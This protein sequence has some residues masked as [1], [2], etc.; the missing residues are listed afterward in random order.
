MQFNTPLIY[1]D[2][3]MNKTCYHKM[4]KMKAQC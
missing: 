2:G 3:V 1:S 4:I